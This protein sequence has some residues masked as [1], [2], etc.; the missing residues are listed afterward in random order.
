MPLKIHCFQHVDYED[1]GCISDWINQNNH[2]LS[3]TRFFE[4]YTFPNV[5]DFDWLIVMGGSMGVYDEKKFPWLKQEKDIIK[6][7]IENNKTIIGIC[8]GSQLI[9]NVLGAKVSKNLE[10]EIGWFEIICTENNILSKHCTSNPLKVFH[11]HGDTFAIPNHA[12]H[13]AYSTACKNQGFLYNEKVLGLQFH[14]EVTQK[15]ILKMLENG[16]EELEEKGNFIQTVNE[17][18]DFSENIPSNNLLMYNI[19]DDLAHEI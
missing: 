2:Q 13:L 18:L 5:Q 1:L 17:I 16:K 3:Y 10:K 14:L 12:V 11:W 15:S 19:L 6:K 4:D 7:A 9:A 8:L